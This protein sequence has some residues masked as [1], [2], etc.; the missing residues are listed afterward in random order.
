M[1]CRR[2][3][4]PFKQHELDSYAAVCKQHKVEVFCPYAIVNMFFPKG[5]QFSY[6]MAAC[7]R[8]EHCKLAHPT[9]SSVNES[10][11]QALRATFAHFGRKRTGRTPAATDGMRS[12]APGSGAAASVEADLAAAG[13]GGGT[14]RGKKKT[15]TKTGTP[16]QQPIG[17]AKRGGKKGNK[18]QRLHTTTIE[19]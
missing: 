17:G 8:G 3:R 6:G 5:E 4:R 15:K 7:K 13:T 1:E 19:E 9:R 18:K 10:L 11:S 12:P 16:F 14:P 2:P